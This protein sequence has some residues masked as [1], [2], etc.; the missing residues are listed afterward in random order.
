MSD[1]VDEKVTPGLPRRTRWMALASVVI[2]SLVGFFSA[3]ELSLLVRSDDTSSERTMQWPSGL[4]IG[5]DPELMRLAWEAYDGALKALSTVRVATLVLLTFACVLASVAALRLLI[6][7]GISRA[8]MRR[9]LVG[10][11]FAAAFLRTI[12]GA[13]TAAV[14]RKMGLVMSRELTRQGPSAAVADPEAWL[15]TMERLPLMFTIAVGVGTA[16]VCGLLLIL[17]QYFRSERV[18][19]AVDTADVFGAEP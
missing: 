4:G 2:T 19:E 9:L 1:A 3:G 16:L 6:P 18:R 17:A 8:A 13:Q 10:A 15:W 11:A 5:D 12:D 14:Y 7:R